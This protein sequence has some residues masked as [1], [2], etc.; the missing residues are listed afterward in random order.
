LSRVYYQTDELIW[1][2]MKMR[3]E[4]KKTFPGALRALHH[5]GSQFFFPPFLFG[6]FEKDGVIQTNRSENEFCF[7]D[8]YVFFLKKL[9][10]LGFRITGSGVWLSFPRPSLSLE[11]K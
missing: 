1:H 2:K 5:R 4:D 9:L 3:R 7:Y 6:L 10:E 8:C 11:G